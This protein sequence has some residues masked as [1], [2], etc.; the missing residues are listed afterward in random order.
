ML[1]NKGC[2]QPC[3][4]S[5]ELRDDRIGSNRGLF[6]GRPFLAQPTPS[7]E[8]R[9]LALTARSYGRSQRAAQGRNFAFAA[10]VRNRRFG[11]KAPL[12]GSPREGPESAGKAS[13]H[14][15][16]EIPFTAQS[17]RRPKPQ[18]TSRWVETAHSVLHDRLVASGASIRTIPLPLVTKQC[19]RVR[20]AKPTHYPRSTNC[21]P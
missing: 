17:P 10:L 8:D 15:E 5:E 21:R 12:R 4:P 11:R 3:R 1:R 9:F 6:H 16:R 20:C 7:A 14:C 13:F 19:G 18:R 2:D